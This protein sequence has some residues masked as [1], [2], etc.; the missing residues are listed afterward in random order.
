[1]NLLPGSSKFFGKSESNVYLSFTQEKMEQEKDSLFIGDLSSQF[2]EDQI[3]ISFV[4]GRSNAR[5]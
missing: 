2:P 4:D 3:R 1:M 5:G